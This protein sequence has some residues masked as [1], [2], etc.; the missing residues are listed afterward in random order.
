MSEDAGSGVCSKTRPASSSIALTLLA[1]QGEPNM[2]LLI[3]EGSSPQ[4]NHPGWIRLLH[5]TRI[6]CIYLQRAIQQR[7]HLLR[8]I[9]LRVLLH[10]YTTADI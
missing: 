8:T 7:N 6:P 4:V 10:E 3:S 1:S 9:G 2:Y 5:S